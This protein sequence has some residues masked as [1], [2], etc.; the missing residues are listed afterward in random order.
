MQEAKELG[1][2]YA[3]AWWLKE[4]RMHLVTYSSK[5]EGST[6]FNTNLYK[7]IM[8]GRFRHTGERRMRIPKLDIKN[9]EKNLDILHRM[10]SCGQFTLSEIQSTMGMIMNGITVDQQ[11]FIRKELDDIKN[12]NQN[13]QTTPERVEEIE[14]GA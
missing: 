4:A 2:I 1:K 10:A 14:D 3:E 7:F 5:E 9:V 13:Q 6:I 11:V 12:G 8:S